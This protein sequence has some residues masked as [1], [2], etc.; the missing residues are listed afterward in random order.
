MG[1]H[2]NEG[3][4]SEI[5]QQMKSNT[6]QLNQEGGRGGGGMNQIPCL[7]VFYS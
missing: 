7:M 5:H 6:N 3:E 4:N 2:P 1:K